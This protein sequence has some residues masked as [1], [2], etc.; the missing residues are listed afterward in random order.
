MTQL[1][2]HYTTL[3]LKLCS[4]GWLQK[5]KSGPLDRL[6]LRAPRIIEGCKGEN[7]GSTFSWPSLENRR[8]YH[9]CLQ[10]FKCLH[11]LVFGYLLNKTG[12]SRRY[13]AYNTGYGDLLLLPL[14]GITSKCQGSFRYKGAKARNTLTSKLRNN[15]S[16]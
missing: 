7:T 12:F 5:N 8:K 11:G 1:L 2:R 16:T 10:L 4:L 13:H 9:T 14:H 15:F 3:R 6:Q